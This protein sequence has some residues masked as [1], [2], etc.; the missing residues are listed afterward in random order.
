MLHSRHHDID[1]LLSLQQTIMEGTQDARQAAMDAWHKAAAAQLHAMGQGW[2]AGHPESQKALAAMRDAEKGLEGHD[3]DRN[4]MAKEAYRRHEERVK[5]RG[6]SDTDQVMRARRETA[7]EQPRPQ[8][9]GAPSFRKLPRERTPIQ[10]VAKRIAAKPKLSRTPLRTEAPFKAQGSGERKSFA[11]TTTFRKAPR[12]S[13][14]GRI[15]TPDYARQDFAKARERLNKRRA[16]V[17]RKADD[18]G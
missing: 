1:H 15:R 12:T 8:R 10:D 7:R 3:I 6:E 13:L 14:A 4:T 11:P 17:E 5:G 2:K 9:G 18:Q 16:D